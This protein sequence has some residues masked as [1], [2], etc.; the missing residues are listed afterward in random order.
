MGVKTF[1]L[2]P[3]AHINPGQANFD[4]LLAEVPQK[5]GAQK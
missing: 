5:K 3:P 2:D 1:A 4:F